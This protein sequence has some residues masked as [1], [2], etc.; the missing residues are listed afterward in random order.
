M[1]LTFYLF[2]RIKSVLT[3]FRKVSIKHHAHTHTRTQKR[4]RP[5]IHMMH[6]CVAAAAVETSRMNEGNYTRSIFYTRAHKI[7]Q[8]KWSVS[9]LIRQDFQNN[10]GCWVWR[11]SRECKWM[12]V[13][14]MS[15]VAAVWRI[16]GGVRQ[17][18]KICKR[19]N[20][21][22]ILISPLNFD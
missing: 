19:A 5:H 4:A 8:L 13:S 12:C 6:R 22:M 17:D 1:V 9:V 21:K 20:Q 11:E 7:R 2:I 18:K 15:T 3:P 16:R 14:S 10:S